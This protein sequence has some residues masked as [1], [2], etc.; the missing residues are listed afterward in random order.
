MKKIRVRK[1]E[2]FSVGR[3]LTLEERNKNIYDASVHCPSEK[4]GSYRTCL[5]KKGHTGRHAI[6][7][8]PG[9][10][11]ELIVTEVWN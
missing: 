5:R 4:P 11:D 2:I 10:K 8:G 6:W 9:E 1:D 7:N 3:K